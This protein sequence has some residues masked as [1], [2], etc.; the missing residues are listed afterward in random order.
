MVSGASSAEYSVKGS[1]FIA[2]ASPITDKQTFKSFLNTI[3]EM[4]P[5]ASHY[6]FAYR[7][8][9]KNVI[10]DRS[11]DNGEPSGTAG[12]PILGQLESREIA[13]SAIIVVRYF[14]GTL[15][16]KPGLIQAYKTAA[17]LVL[18]CAKIEKKTIQAFYKLECDY[19]KLNRVLDLLNRH[20]C[21]VTGIE[22]LLFARIEAGFPKV[23]ELRIKNLLEEM[24]I[25]VTALNTKS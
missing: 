1:K 23:S 4:H 8:V 3:R 17:S 22:N 16:G 12:K 5:K 14:G 6:C 21:T 15:L 24:Q 7:I 19:T 9:K 18:Q 10:E 25:E 13:D 11:S 20:G 2:F